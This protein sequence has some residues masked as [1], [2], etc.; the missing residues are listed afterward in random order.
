MARTNAVCSGCLQYRHDGKLLPRAPFM[1]PVLMTCFSLLSVR[2]I[3]TCTSEEANFKVMTATNGVLRLAAFRAGLLLQSSVRAERNNKHDGLSVALGTRRSNVFSSNPLLLYSSR[4]MH[5]W[6]GA[7][8]LNSRAFSAWSPLGP[9]LV[10]KA[11]LSMS[12]AVFVQGT[13]VC[14]CSIFWANLLLLETELFP[15]E[16]GMVASQ[17]RPVFLGTHCRRCFA[18]GGVCT[19]QCDLTHCRIGGDTTNLTPMLSAP[20]R[21][22]SHIRVRHVR[23]AQR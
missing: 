2:F 21:S 7:Y 11:I 6:R 19:R 17:D 8:A 3:T 14:C 23:Y 13:T 20:S 9:Q 16:A 1:S 12:T 18:S 5:A 22:P 4:C 15:M 10:G